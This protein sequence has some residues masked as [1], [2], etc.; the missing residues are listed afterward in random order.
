VSGLVI[1]AVPSKEGKHITFH[2]ENLNEAKIKYYVY[3]QEFYPLFK[4]R[5]SVDIIFYLINLWYIVTTKHFYILTFRESCI[6][7]I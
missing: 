5:R 1:G 4:Y 7:D 2:S 3:D 6:R